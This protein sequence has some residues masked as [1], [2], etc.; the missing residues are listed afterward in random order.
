MSAAIMVHVDVDPQSNDRVRLAA[1]LAQRFGSD[2]IGI[3]AAMLP[4]DPSETAY[5][6]T[7]N[8]SNSSNVQKLPFGPLPA[9][10]DRGSN[11]DPTSISLKVTLF[12]NCGPR[13]S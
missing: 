4:A 8:M 5:F 2:L 6:V 9:L 10:T 11:G 12:P 1:R 3:S 13:I 7:R